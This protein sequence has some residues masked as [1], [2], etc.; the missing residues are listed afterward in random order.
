MKKLNTKL[1]LAIVFSF[2]VATLIPR[3]LVRVFKVAVP[4]EFVDSPVVLIGGLLSAFIALSL[5]ALI[6][7]VIFMKRIKT[8][9]EATLRVQQGQYNQLIEEHGNDEISSLIQTFNDM[10]QALSSNQYLNQEFIRNMSH[11]FKTPLTV[12]SSLIQSME[13]EEK[14]KDRLLEEIDQLASLTSTL[15]TLSKVDSLEHLVIKPFDVN[16]LIR[17]LVISKQPLWEKKDLEWDVS[18]D[19]V[20]LSSYAPYVYEMFSNLIDN[21][22]QYAYLNTLLSIEVVKQNNIVSITFSNRG[23]SLTQDEMEHMFELFY[24]GSQSSGSGVGLNLVKSI[25]N[26]LKGEMSITSNEER[27]TFKITLPQL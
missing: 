6:S 27:T 5:F 24:K 3:L 26:R 7:N 9:Q 15:L 22:I 13:T 11:Q 2:F 19:S 10:Q 16:E 8:L 12:M 14:I 17:R 4:V 21:M 1:V 25:L 18:E 20:W 23:P